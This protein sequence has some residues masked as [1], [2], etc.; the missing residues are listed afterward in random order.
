MTIKASGP[1]K[2]S[3]DIAAEFT[4]NTG[5]NMSSM[6]NARWY[7]DSGLETGTFQTTNL[8]FSSFYSKRA[9]DPAGSGSQTYTPGNHSFIVPLYRNSI[10]FYAWGGGGS[11]AAGG[12]GG[13]STVALPGTTLYAG[14]GGAGGGGGRRTI[15]G[16]GGGGG[17]SGGT[18]GENGQG[19]GPCPGNGGNAGGMSF[20]GGAGA[21]YLGGNFTY[22]P[23]NTPGG[24]G[25]GF[26]GYDGSP[27]PGFSGGGGGGGGGFSG[28]TYGPGE[29]SVG[30]SVNIQ[31]ATQ[32]G[33]G[34]TA[35]VRVIWT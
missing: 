14:G 7:K 15:S 21:T 16:A 11:S 9:T 23:G 27:D 1:I 20:G 26:F 13:A 24:G 25:S 33:N 32:S 19:G 30:T 35:R 2:L 12:N 10:T 29:L 6:R 3:A 18:L 22:Y 31:V 8:S 5:K 17:Q 34:G 28:K 4:T